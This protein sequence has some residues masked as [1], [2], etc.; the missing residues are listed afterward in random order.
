MR[1]LPV[2]T[3]YA[4]AKPD[5]DN[6]VIKRAANKLNDFSFVFGILFI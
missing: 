3:V 6:T 4:K 1:G 2:A 5:N